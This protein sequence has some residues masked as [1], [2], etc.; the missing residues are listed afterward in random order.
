MRDRAEI[1]RL[2]NILDGVDAKSRE[3]FTVFTTNYKNAIDGV[4]IRPGRID[5]VVSLKSPD[6]GAAVRLVRKYGRNE[7]G[8]SILA[9]DLTDEAI[10]RA[11]TV[12][13]EMQA[14]AAFYREAVERAKLSALPHY[15]ATGSLALSE[16]NIRAA[17]LSM[18][19]HIELLQAQSPGADGRTTVA[20]DALSAM[21]N[22]A[23]YPPAGVLMK[24]MKMMQPRASSGF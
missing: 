7:K 19:S 9:E 3:I 4:F 13:V 11:V 12:L 21:F 10:G 1:N 24:L 16:E 22:Q 14:N 20:D 2:T 8:A 5:C 18:Q 6:L 23:A 17:A 15:V